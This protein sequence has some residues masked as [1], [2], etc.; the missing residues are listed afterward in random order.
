MSIY[1]CLLSTLTTFT[2][3]ECEIEIVKMFMTY[4]R[5]GNEDYLNPSI[6]VAV[7]PFEPSYVY[8]NPSPNT[9]HEPLQLNEQSE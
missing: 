8:R 9:L 1:L 4:K 7:M 6:W 5:T 2:N 3:S